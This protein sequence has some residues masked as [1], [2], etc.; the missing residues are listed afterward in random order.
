MFHYL[1]A[2]VRFR[3][4]GPS[5]WGYCGSFSICGEGLFSEERKKCLLAVRFAVRWPHSSVSAPPRHGERAFPR[6]LGTLAWRTFCPGRLLL[7]GSFLSSLRCHWPSF[8]HLRKHTLFPH[9]VVSTGERVSRSCC[10]RRSSSLPVLRTWVFAYL[11]VMQCVR[12]KKSAHF[13]IFFSLP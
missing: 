4:P 1:V 8:R 11:S 13:F 9:L 3:A 5:S 2:I 7:I 10:S 6:Y 12:M